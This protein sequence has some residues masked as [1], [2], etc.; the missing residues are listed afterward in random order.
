MSEELFEV[1]F[2]GEIAEGA[3]LAQVKAKVGAMF[4]ADEAKLAHLFSGK[5]MVIKKNIDQATANKY[6]TALNNAGAICELKSLNAEPIEKPAAAVSTPAPTPAPAAP[7]AQPA[8]SASSVQAASTPMQ[9][10]NAPAAPQTA[11]L[12][13]T[14]SDIADFSAGIAPVGSDMQ[15]EISEI[16]TPDLDIAGLDMAPA[17]SDLG[18]EK[19]DDAPP[20]PDT[21]GMTMA[22]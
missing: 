10:G 3:D 16:A 15:D 5:R 17:G 2:S 1:A 6:K 4:K 7:V 18:Q 8:S 13:V 19:K 20:P 12:G 21:T 14:A 9:S 22:D 11:P